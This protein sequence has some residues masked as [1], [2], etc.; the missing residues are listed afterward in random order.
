LV[1]L[2]DLLSKTIEKTGT[3]LREDRGGHGTAYH[4]KYPSP[5]ED[6]VVDCWGLFEGTRPGERTNSPTGDFAKLVEGIWL[7]ATGE[8]HAPG[9]RKVLPQITDLMPESS[10]P[11]SFFVPE[12][13]KTHLVKAVLRAA[14]TVEDLAEPVQENDYS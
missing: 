9:V 5:I 14:A 3:E 12:G 11:H 2:F 10:V 6:L 13:M 8:L 1:Q 4:E 7:L